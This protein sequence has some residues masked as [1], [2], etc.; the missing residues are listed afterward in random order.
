MYLEEWIELPFIIVLRCIPEFLDSRR[1]C[2]TLDV[3]LWALDSERWALESR[4]WTLDA[5]LWT[6][7]AGRWT[8]HFRCWALVTEHY[9]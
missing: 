2:W 8:L 3:G 7:D 1:K 9:H 5:G 6:F 4:P